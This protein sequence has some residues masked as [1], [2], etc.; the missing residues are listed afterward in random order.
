[1]A[2]MSEFTDT[3]NMDAG[4]RL[5]VYAGD[6]GGYARQELIRNSDVAM[7][8]Y[9]RNVSISNKTASPWIG[10]RQTGNN[11]YYNISLTG[12]A[13]NPDTSSNWRAANDGKFVIVRGAVR[14]PSLTSLTKIGT[15]PNSWK[16]TMIWETEQL[17]VVFQ[18]DENGN[19][20]ARNTTGSSVDVRLNTIVSI[21]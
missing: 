15:L 2:Q 8:T 1:M 12:G 19:I 17:G 7:E 5:V 3:P 20:S 13:S 14:V 6:N 18:F 21:F 9:A 10:F 4:A 16:P 11:S